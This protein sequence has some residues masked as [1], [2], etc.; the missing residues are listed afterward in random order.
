M[1]A[2]ISNLGPGEFVLVLIVAVLIF[3]RRL[4][5]VAARGAIQIQKLRRGV[6]EF[7]RESGFDEEMR[8]ARQIIEDPVRQALK[9]MYQTHKEVKRPFVGRH[10]D[11][12]PEPEETAAVK[13]IEM[14]SKA[15]EAVQ[16]E[17]ADSGAA[18]EPEP[19]IERPAGE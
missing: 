19:P 2:F 1:L 14:P 13:V 6:Q 11:A 9:E 4:P 12:L 7:R 18:K 17:L 5:E 15:T 3:G 16:P 8:K 10:P